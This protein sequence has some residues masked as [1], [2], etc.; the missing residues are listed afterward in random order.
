MIRRLLGAL[1]LGFVVA[2]LVGAPPASAIPGI[3]DCKEAPTPDVPGQGIA[4]FFTRTPDPLPAHADPFASVSGTTIYEQYGYG[5]LRWSTYDLGCG[6][7]TM[8]NPDAV[9]GTAFANWIMQPPLALT[10][11]TD[12]VTR[13]AFNPSFLGVFD[14]VVERV[15]GALHRSLFATWV[16]AVIAVVGVLVL[17]RAN[18]SSLS[19]SAA[20]AGWALIVVIAATALFRWPVEAGQMADKTVTTTLGAVASKLDGR[21][22][23]VD[24]GTAVASNVTES[25]FYRSWLAGTLGSPDSETARRYGPE[26]FKAQALTWSE[27]ATVQ[28]DPERGE[29]IIEAKQERWKEIAERIEEDDPTAYAHLTGQRSDTRFGYAFLAGLAAFLALP[30]LLLSALLLLGCFLIVR[31]AVMLFPA[32]ATL[33]AFPAARGLVT[34]IAKTVGAAVVNSIVFGIGA[35]VTISVLG[36]LMHPGGGAPGWLGLV[37]MPLFSFVMWAALRPFRRL[38]AMVKPDEPFRSGARA[39][40][41]AL[42]AT[43]GFMK[44]AGTAAVG[45]ATGGVAAAVA[46]R[47]M[48][49]EEKKNKKP[50]TPDRAE[51]HPVSAHERPAP[52]YAHATV[53]HMEPAHPALPAAPA[54]TCPD[55]SGPPPPPPGPR[56][57]DEPSTPRPFVSEPAREVSTTPQPAEPAESRWRPGSHAAEAQGH[58]TFAPRAPGG[59]APLMPAEAEWDGDDEVYAIYRPADPDSSTDDREDEDVA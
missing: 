28:K 25:I 33:G 34:G 26:L 32:F 39:S 7:D 23:S 48:A 19:T 37:L 2:G 54:A 46:A 47:R 43:G 3:P 21:S 1:V 27:A 40:A 18:R 45:A 8:R 49:E 41:D 42:A 24:P 20:A 4:G 50:D 29:E 5:G 12:S 30:F 35:A 9:I 56:P 13:V 16:P 57:A 11:L 59:E 52:Q 51:A 10:A 55:P 38:T 44:Q 6:P 15:S 31:L 14:P 53:V 17:F 58:G 22:D 36:V